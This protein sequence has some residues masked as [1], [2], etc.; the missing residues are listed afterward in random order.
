[1]AVDTRS[2]SHPRNNAKAVSVVLVEITTRGANLERLAEAPACLQA[3]GSLPCPASRVCFPTHRAAMHQPLS[4]SR[5]L[6][7]CIAGIGGL[8]MGVR[9]LEWNGTEWVC[10]TCWGLWRTLAVW[11]VN[12]S[13]QSA[14]WRT[15]AASWAYCTRCSGITSVYCICQ[16]H[17]GAQVMCYQYMFVGMAYACDGGGVQTN[18]ASHAYVMRWEAHNSV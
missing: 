8:G 12:L 16:S 6:M 4:D 3:V 9:L 7:A 18:G 17:T 11:S 5:H 2:C 1:M 15:M 13:E 14:T 10:G